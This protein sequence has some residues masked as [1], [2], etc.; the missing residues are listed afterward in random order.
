LNLTAANRIFILEPQWNPSIEIQAIARA[1]R[2]LQNQSVSVIRYIV[3]GTVEEV[4]QISRFSHHWKLVADIEVGDTT[5]ARRQDR[6]RGNG[7]SAR[8]N[9]VPTDLGEQCLK[10]RKWRSTWYKV[11]TSFSWPSDPFILYG[12]SFMHNMER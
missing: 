5:A 8:L 10:D 3:R 12:V 4:G 7:I 2:L 11:A 6:S 9:G 1:Q